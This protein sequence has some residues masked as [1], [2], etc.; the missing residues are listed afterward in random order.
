MTAIFTL[1]HTSCC[2]CVSLTAI[3]AEDMIAMLKQKKDCL[4]S[5]AL[6]LKASIIFLIKNAKYLTDWHC[7]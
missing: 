1:L 4:W 2:W 7:E 6:K 3:N 5:G